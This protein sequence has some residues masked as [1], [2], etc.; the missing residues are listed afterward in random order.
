[1][2]TLLPFAF[3]I[4]TST[5]AISDTQRGIEFYN[6]EDFAQA[7]REFQGPVAQGDP[8]A[9]RYY[10][11][12]LYMGR[13]VDADRERAKELLRGAY[14]KGDTASGTYLASLLT[15]FMLHWTTDEE[16]AAKIARLS[17][18]TQLFEETYT[19]PTSQKP[20]TQIVTSA[21]DT[22]GQVAPKGDMMVWFKRAVRERH[23][24]SAWYLA[25]AHSNGNGAKKDFAEAFYW[26][27]YAAFLGQPEAQT[28]VGELYAEGRFGPPRPDA[29]LALIVQAAKERHNPAMLHVAGH[30]A[31]KGEDFGMAWR[32]LQLAYDRGMEKSEGSKRLEEFLISRNG[33]YDA[34]FIEDYAYNGRFET[35]I[36]S[37]LPDYNAALKDFE[38]RI[39]PYSE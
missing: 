12:M 34:R 22:D 26:A 10:A 13:G 17:E 6:A 33:N 19:G 7:E 30:F 39:R 31:G 9:I 15:D 25:R 37:T 24:E 8:V 20:A 32:V 23:G 14:E 3:L 29:G 28:T 21:I 1:M 4:L 18:A 2:R 35:L 27:E 5:T 36:Q 11:N 16:P 38:S